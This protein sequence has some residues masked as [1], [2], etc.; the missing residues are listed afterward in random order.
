MDGI[1]N[2]KAADQHALGADRDP[3]DFVRP[4]LAGQLDHQ[5]LAKR[6]AFG[7]QRRQRDRHRHQAANAR[8][9]VVVEDL[10]LPDLAAA[11]ADPAEVGGAIFLLQ[12]LPIEQ[13]KARLADISC[14]IE[15]QAD[16]VQFAVAD[17]VNEVDV[18]A[19]AERTEP[20]R[21]AEAEDRIPLAHRKRQGQ[22]EHQTS[23]RRLQLSLV[24]PAEQAA[25]GGQ[26]GQL[27]RHQLEVA[28]AAD[29][30]NGQELQ[31][32]IALLH[33]GPGPFR[34]E[35]AQPIDALDPCN[36]D[37]SERQATGI[38]DAKLRLPSAVQTRQQHLL[39]LGAGVLVHEAV[40]TQILEAI[41][42]AGGLDRAIGAGEIAHLEGDHIVAVCWG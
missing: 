27:L 30:L 26:G 6:L 23:A 8:R 10:H 21:W 1:G 4:M 5:G 14:R 35:P 11:I 19:A 18:F 40:S 7:L 13:L 12:R 3:T 15:P 33:Q 17:A 22:G 31:T 39:T 25:V 34:A 37:A 42:R 41:D 20:A 32:L 9:T 29:Q 28:G 2:I 36:L 24:S 38:G 16:A